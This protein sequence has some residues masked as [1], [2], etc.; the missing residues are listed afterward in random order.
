MLF[1]AKP[2]GDFTNTWKNIK[3]GTKAFLE[4][5]FGSFILPEKEHLFLV[6]GG[7]GITP[8]MS[9]LRTLRDRKDSRKAILIYGSKKWEEVTFR[10][11]LEELKD[12]INL[13]L[14]HL[15]ME[16]PDDWEGE[17][18][19]IDQEFLEKY[20]PKNK[21]EYRYFI[22]GPEPMMDITELALRDLNVDWRHIYTER[23]KIV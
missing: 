22:C 12:Q 7:I 16:P 6:M 1:T 13:E 9:M 17:T 18:G 8:A 5:P 10:E 14:I 4:G 19:I 15:L 21:H 20:L 11:E 23:F 3:P 2:G